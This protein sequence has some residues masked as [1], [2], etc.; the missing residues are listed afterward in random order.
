MP[1]DRATWK[2]AEADQ[3]DCVWFLERAVRRVERGYCGWSFYRTRWWRAHPAFCM[4]GAL[5]YT[6]DGEREDYHSFRARIRADA[7]VTQ[8]TAGK[9]LVEYGTRWGPITRPRVLRAYRAALAH[10]RRDKEKEG[11]A[12][13]R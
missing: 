10:A 6:D 4:A 11:I 7:Y 2:E 8:E 9:S 12:S 3:R 1:F 5:D 13:C